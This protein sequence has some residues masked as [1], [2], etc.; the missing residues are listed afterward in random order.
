VHDARVAEILAA[1]PDLEGTAK[2]L[3]DTANEAGGRDNVTAL[4]VR[5]E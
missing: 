3:V 5:I 1:G 2:S 4:L